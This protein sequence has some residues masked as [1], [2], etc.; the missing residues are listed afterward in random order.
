MTA[1]KKIKVLTQNEEEAIR[2]WNEPG[3]RLIGQRELK[4][5]GY[6]EEQC[7]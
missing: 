3:L 5:L 4:L 1:N 2:L 7:A 6:S